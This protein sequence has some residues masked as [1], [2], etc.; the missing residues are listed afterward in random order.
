M[1]CARVASQPWKAAQSLL[2]LSQK[3]RDSLALE[4]MRHR[5]R[6]Q[7]GATYGG[8]AV[9]GPGAARE[10]H[11]VERHVNEVRL[12][13]FAP[14]GLPLQAKDFGGAERGAPC[15]RHAAIISVQDTKAG[16]AESRIGRLGAMHTP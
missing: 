9:V 10:A 16:A 12:A 15:G 14:R 3:R 8:H 4:L 7:P 13:A 5:A 1:F 11:V 6:R 2:K